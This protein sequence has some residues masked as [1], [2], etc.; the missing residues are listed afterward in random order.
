MT[1]FFRKVWKRTRTL[2]V[3]IL[4][5]FLTLI[6]ISFF[7]VIS[8]TYSR[9]YKTILQFSKGVAEQCSAIVVTKFQSIAVGAERVTKTSGGFFPEL[10]PLGFKNRLMLSYM[11]NLVKY[12][13][14][15]SNFFLGLPDGSFI[16]VLS[17]AVSAQKTYLT[18]PG[19]LLP[20]GTAFSLRFV[21]YSQNPVVDYWYYLAQD[22]KEV[23][24]EV[25]SPS[26]SDSRSR[27][28][29][30]GAEKN[31]SLYWTGF[32]SFLPTVARGISISY[33]M[34]GKNKELL[35]ILGADLTMLL[36]D[37]FVRSQRIGSNGRVY[38]LDEQGKIV[39]P[40]K[41]GGVDLGALD[42]ALIS[43]VYQRYIANPSQ[44]DI[45]IRFKR[46]QYLGYVS[47]LP[48]VFGADWYIAAV[49][50]SKDFF[51]D[52]IQV[53]NQVLG[54]I[55]VILLLSGLIVI[56]FAKK[57]A[58]PIVILAQEVDKIRRLDLQSEVRVHSHIH[59]ICLMDSA[60]ASMRRVIRSFSRYVPKEIVKDLFDKNE[61][62]ALGGKKKE[63]TL[64]FSD[65]ANFTTIAEKESIDSLIPLMS[66]YFDA[67]SKIIL[68]AHG[69]IDKFIGDGIMAF[70]GAPIEFA[71]HGIRACTTALRCSAMLAHLNR[72]RR[73]EG[74]PEFLTR[75][76]VNTGTVIVGNIGTE[77]R[78]NYTVIGNAV[79]VTA[80]LQE[81][82]KVFHTS[83]IIGQEVLE[84]LEGK[85]VTRPLDLVAVKGK[86]EKTRI[87]EL[88]GVLQGDREIQATSDQI[89]LS[90][91][92][93]AA[94][95]VM[96]KGDWKGAQTLFQ[97]IS[98]QY[99]EDYPTQIYLKKSQE[100][101]K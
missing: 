67:M 20:A 63:V 43:L 82:D 34:Y 58:S 12:D 92:F 79:N 91:A 73:E 66:E 8:F 25:I 94:F 33:P 32:Y 95:D 65:I 24:R 41:E 16:G 36:L 1:N 62:I 47:K 4:T 2:K 18:D 98:A 90:Q 27:P 29:Y 30:I 40:G 38:I 70:W 76:G 39:V 50:P 60:V 57:V 100:L 48:V 101:E 80:R 44:P 7:C 68:E 61:E 53:Q 19:K 74:R 51:A 15:L 83:I 86:R 13:I 35:G 10:E 97:A 3:N 64:F 22:F 99:P 11:L 31:R 84:K 9:N 14:H 71:D 85:F 89:A 37:N 54:I 6:C 28:W 52:L 81:V 49:A 17:Q 55:V 42:P 87:Y 77:D 88:M 5:F 59:E 96:Q 75:F 93:A 72:K 45:L 78:M 21:D 46:E 23:G 69:T 26:E 56:Y